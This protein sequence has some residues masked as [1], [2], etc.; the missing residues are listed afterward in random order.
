MRQ[1]HAFTNLIF[2][3]A[4]AE[5]RQGRLWLVPGKRLNDSTAG[6]PCH[7]LRQCSRDGLSRRFV[8]ADEVAGAMPETRRVRAV[9][10][11]GVA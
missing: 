3:A 10:E 5:A 11:W 9:G 6:I 4:Q 2:R 1:D 7:P 8:T